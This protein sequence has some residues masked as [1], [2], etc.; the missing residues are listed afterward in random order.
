MSEM[1]P[2]YM[3]MSNATLSPFAYETP[4]H[5]LCEREDNSVPQ[6]LA[7]ATFIT[8]LIYFH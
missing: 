4:D 3:S 7:A 2:K 5:P 1:T 8:T 6:F